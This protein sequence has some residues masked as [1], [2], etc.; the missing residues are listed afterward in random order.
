M[1]QG[2]CVM[3]KMGFGSHSLVVV[4]T[5]HAAVAVFQ[6]LEMDYTSGPPNRAYYPTAL[7]EVPI[8]RMFG[9]T[10]EGAAVAS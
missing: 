3:A 8:V 2:T 4:A 1:W 5:R 6:Q 9:N 7:Q 10:E